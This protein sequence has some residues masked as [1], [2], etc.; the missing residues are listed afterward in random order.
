MFM[1]IQVYVCGFVFLCVWVSVSMYVRIYACMICSNFR[2]M[3]KQTN[4]RMKEGMNERTKE[5]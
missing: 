1:S 4:E 5:S 2:W 3:E